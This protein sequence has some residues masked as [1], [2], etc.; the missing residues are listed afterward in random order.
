[1]SIPTGLATQPVFSAA[2]TSIGT[3]HWS[4]GRTPPPI[5]DLKGVATYTRPAITSED[6]ARSHDPLSTNAQVEWILQ[7][8][9]VETER[10][11]NSPRL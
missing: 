5:N 11:G 9:G 6:L 3:F 2:W 1:M 8:A 7:D 10:L 4:L